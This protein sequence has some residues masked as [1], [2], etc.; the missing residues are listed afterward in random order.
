MITDC[1]LVRR[2]HAVGRSAGRVQQLLQRGAF[3]L[4]A[5]KLLPI[6]SGSRG[7][8][9]HVLHCVDVA[10]DRRDH[11]AGLCAGRLGM[12]ARER[13]AAARVAAPA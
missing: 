9:T 1:V 7:H 11:G 13:A 4:E 2:V 8:L 3:A 5:L 6:R 10:G 12:Q